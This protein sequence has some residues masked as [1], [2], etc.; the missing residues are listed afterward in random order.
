MAAPRIEVFAVFNPSTGA[1]LTGAAGG[2]S[3]STYTDDL[4]VAVTPQPSIT[5]IGGGLYRFTPTFPPSASR[6]L[7]YVV[8]TG[9]NVPAYYFRLVRPEDWN[10]DKIQDLMDVAFG[11]WQI[12]STGPDANRI[13]LYRADGVTVLARF[14]LKNLSGNPSITNVFQRIP[15]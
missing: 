15:A 6:A 13:V 10:A 2:M 3:F 5:E 9:G 8:N 1:P 12:F 7:V 4:G 14:D 11:K